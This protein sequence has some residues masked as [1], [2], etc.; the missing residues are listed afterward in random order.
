MHHENTVTHRLEEI[1]FSTYYQEDELIRKFFIQ[2]NLAL[3]NE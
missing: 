2:L 3:P 1:P